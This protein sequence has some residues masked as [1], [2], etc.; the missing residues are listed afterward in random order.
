MKRN[1]IE[2]IEDF[3]LN[4][5]E[6]TL[7]IN[8]VSEE[9]GSFYE[10]IVNFLSLKNRVKLKKEEYSEGNLASN[11]LFENNKKIYIYYIT[12]NKVIDKVIKKNHAKIIFTDYK[13]YKRFLKKLVTINAYEFEKDIIHFLKNYLNIN[14]QNLVDFCISQPHLTI[15]ELSKYNI[16]SVGYKK[17]ASIKHKNNFILD[18]RKK[19]IQS[20]RSEINVKELFLKLKEEV[21]YKKFNFLAY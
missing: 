12:A 14:N 5:S 9:I 8:Y 20:K 6:E 21:K 15:S 16:N 19:I 1:N 10:I 13:N 7:L 18:I 17:D 11:D 3:I 4:K 2:I